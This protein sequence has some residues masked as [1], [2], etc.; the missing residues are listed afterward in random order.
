MNIQGLECIE[1]IP[2]DIVINNINHIKCINGINMSMDIEYNKCFICK[3]YVYIKRILPF[4]FYCSECNI[5]LCIFC[6]IKHIKNHHRFKRIIGPEN[7][8]IIC[9]ICD[10]VFYTDLIYRDY[11]RDIDC[12]LDCSIKPEGKKLIDNNRLE[13]FLFKN[14][15]NTAN[16][17]KL[18]EWVVIYKDDEENYIIYCDN[19]NSIHYDCYGLYI[20]DNMNKI[21]L[22]SLSKKWK[23]NDLKIIL[24]KHYNNIEWK[25]MTGLNYFNNHP[26]K[27]FMKD[28]NMMTVFNL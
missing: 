12:C 22:Y 23:I 6:D 11:I 8:Y 26:I 7:I 3:K 24:E 15:Y 5:N 13:L 1:N 14:K 16:F 2:L 4:F 17:G 18:Y 20:T 28:N 10:K 9:N 21:G 25:L 27:R 19:I